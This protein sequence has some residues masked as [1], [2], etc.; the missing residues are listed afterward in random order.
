MLRIEDL[1]GRLAQAKANAGSALLALGARLC[2]CRWPY[3]NYA[4]YT[5]GMSLPLLRRS[6]GL[7]A[8]YFVEDTRVHINGVSLGE[9]PPIE[10][11]YSSTTVFG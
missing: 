11:V 4:G 5:G 7:I 6:K 8:R 10:L 1:S 3:I 9:K 2:I